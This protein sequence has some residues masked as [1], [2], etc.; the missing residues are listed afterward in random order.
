MFE[1]FKD[2]F[3]G[4]ER[5]HGEYIAG[6]LDEKGKKGGKAFIKKTPVT[7]DMWSAHLRGDNPSLGIVPIN[8]DVI[9]AM[10]YCIMSLR[11]ARVKNYEPTYV[12]ADSEFSI[13][14]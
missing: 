11:K 7:D 5:A 12:Q 1:K 4:L 3:S 9:S 2:I 14:A 6:D 8:D 10:R 13:F